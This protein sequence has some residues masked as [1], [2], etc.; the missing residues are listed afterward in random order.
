LNEE[1]THLLPLGW[2]SDSAKP[3]QIYDMQGSC[4]DM[5]FP[6]KRKC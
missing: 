3:Y 4:A 1:I 5:S 6:Y 2:A